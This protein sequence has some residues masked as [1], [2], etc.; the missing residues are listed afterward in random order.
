MGA[1]NTARA[2]AAAGTDYGFRPLSIEE[3]DEALYLRLSAIMDTVRA[4]RLR[5]RGAGPRPEWERDL[6]AIEDMLFD[7]VNE[8]DFVELDCAPDR[9]NVPR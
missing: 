2:D 5:I 9:D 3:A 7:L 4:L 6:K 8:A 1:T